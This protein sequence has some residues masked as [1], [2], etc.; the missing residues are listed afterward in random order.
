LKKLSYELQPFN[1]VIQAIKELSN[2]KS[3]RI[4][5]DIRFRHHLISYAGHQFG[6]RAPGKDYRERANGERIDNW[7]AEIGMLIPTY[8]QLVDAYQ[9]D[10][11]LSTIDSDNLCF[12]YLEKMLELLRPWSVNLDLD[13]TGRIDI[14]DKEQIALLLVRSI[15]TELQIAF[16]HTERSRFDQAENHCQ[17]AL[18]HARLY[19]GK[20][21]EKTNL[22]CKA[23]RGYIHLR[24]S[25][26]KYADAVIFAEE[27]YNL[28]AVAYNPVHPKVQEAAG[29]LIECLIHTGDLF[30]AERFAQATLDSLKDPGNGLNQESEEVA[31]GYYMLGQVIHQQEGDFVRAEM[32]V[33]ESLRIRSQLYCH[34]TAFIGMSVGLLASILKSQGKL[35]HETR[36]LYERSLAIRIKRNG[37][38]GKNAAVANQHMAVFYY[39]LAEV[40][41][42]AETRIEH[43]RLSLSYHKEA[44]RIYTVT[45][46]PDNPST[47]V[48]SSNVSIISRELSEAL[49]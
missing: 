20:E 15:E 36:E 21:E 46:G 47:M 23:L 43:L 8:C 6:D 29:V 7:N 25:Q 44:M 19:E 18:S 13:S 31:D 5:L 3:K 27:A 34:D 11:S 40:Q 42:T 2:E 16:I 22:L 32:L 30:N 39:N 1:E 17:Q 28:V 37:P 35:G 38:D 48:E 10:E 24:M 41:E 4:D 45:L 26:E 49:G 14:L 33:R 9:W 12:P